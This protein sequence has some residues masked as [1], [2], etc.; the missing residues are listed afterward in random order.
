MQISESELSQAT[1]DLDEMHHATLPAMHEAVDAWVDDLRAAART[2][3]S[4]PTTR[5]GLLFGGGGALVGALALAA[6]G[7]TKTTRSSSG[8]TTTSPASTSL[9]GDFAIAALSASLENLAVQTYQAGLDA[10]TAGKLGTVPPAVATFASTVKAQH[11]DH[12]AAWNAIL[13]NAGKVAVTGID[14][15]LR[16]GVVDPG[17]AQVS[18]VAGLARLALGLENVAAATY[19]NS[20]AIIENN[21]ALKTAASIQPVEMQHAAI[22]NFVLGQYPVPDSFARTDGARPSTDQIG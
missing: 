13:T 14:Q 19:L 10:A 6:C 18:D 1:S 2:G 9:T 21:N 5:R 22:L 17:F 3:A 20:I 4:T 7:S 11:S 16:S 8:E 15:T 12:A